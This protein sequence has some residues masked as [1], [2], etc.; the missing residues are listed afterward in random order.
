MEGEII[1]KY[2]AEVTL[3]IDKTCDFTKIFEASTFDL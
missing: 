1:S 3:F 2:L